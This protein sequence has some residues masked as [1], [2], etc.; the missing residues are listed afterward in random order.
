M[1]ESQPF[2][3]L[4]LLSADYFLLRVSLTTL[5][6]VPTNQKENA[7]CPYD[8]QINHAEKQKHGKHLKWDWL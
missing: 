6:N 7:V 3:Y 1:N 4:E 2:Q 8:V 5:V